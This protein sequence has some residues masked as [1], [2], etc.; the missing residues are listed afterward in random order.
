MIHFHHDED[1]YLNRLSCSMCF[2]F[3][4]QD[5]ASTCIYADGDMNTDVSDVMSLFANHLMQFCSDGG[6]ILHSK[7]LMADNSYIYICEA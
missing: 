1:K 4:I 7:V 6:L 2:F 3:F 5:N